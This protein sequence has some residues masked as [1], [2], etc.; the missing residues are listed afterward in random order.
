M[1]YT[2]QFIDG[3][4]ITI[5][6]EEFA[7][8][9][10]KSGLVFIPSIRETINM[11]SISRIY[12]TENAPEDKDH[13]LGVL[14]DGTRVIRQFGEWFC[15][16]GERDEKGLYAV[17]P[18]VTFYRE[19]AMDCVPSIETYQT[20]Y[21]MLST[22]ERKAKMI[23]GKDTARYEREGGFSRISETMET[24]KLELPAP[25]YCECHSA[26]KVDCSCSEQESEDAKEMQD[27]D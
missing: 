15:M 10:G 7:K 24:K 12:P 2:I 22:D 1:T 6:E 11:M 20:K 21:Q 3:S 8:L 26:F 9:A 23:E 16:A 18:D 17:R 5:T 19:V 25:D 13:K 14:H 27:D 4:R